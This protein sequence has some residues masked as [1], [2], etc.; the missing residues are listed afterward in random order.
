MDLITISNIGK[1][2]KVN[3]EQLCEFIDKLIEKTGFR[4]GKIPAGDELALMTLDLVG[5][6]N[7]D[8]RSLTPNDIDKAFEKGVFGEY[9]EFYG[10]NTRTFVMWLDSYEKN[11]ID[12]IAPITNK[13]R[14]IES[15]CNL[16]EEEKD[17][18]MQAAYD[19]CFGY[20]EKAGEI[21][22]F[23]NA[24]YDWLDKKGLIDLTVDEKNE[25]FEQAKREVI[26]R[27]KQRA[28]FEGSE[29]NTPYLR[30]IDEL[31][32]GGEKKQVISTAKRIALKLYFSRK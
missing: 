2:Y 20:F 30:L 15:R 24:V 14:L 7:R 3:H 6:I 25:I 26:S 27:T 22:D 4:F 5:I 31:S 28:V 16:T 10:L 32:Q 18:L 9:G 1:A 12:M 13:S 19:R 29:L 21:R 23:G 11:R 17:K 8:Y